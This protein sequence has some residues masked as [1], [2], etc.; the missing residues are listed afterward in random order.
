MISP[1][2]AEVY[3]DT[4]KERTENL[5]IEKNRSVQNM[6]LKGLLFSCKKLINIVDVICDC[7]E[8]R[9]ENIEHMK[10]Q[11]SKFLY[12]IQ[13]CD[14]YGAFP[15]IIPLFSITIHLQICFGY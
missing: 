8:Y 6:S 9:I 1:Q 5:N 13:K 14:G 3:C 4:A 7:S 12:P 2:F 11:F 10:A 15:T